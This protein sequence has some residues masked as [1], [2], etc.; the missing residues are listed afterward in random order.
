MPGDVSQTDKQRVLES[1]QAS[2]AHELR[3][4]ADRLRALPT[5]AWEADERERLKR[6]AQR[7]E[8]F[9]DGKLWEHKAECER[10]RWERIE[11]HGRIGRLVLEAARA[12]VRTGVMA[13]DLE[14][15]RRATETTDGF[16][17]PAAALAF[18][19]LLEGNALAGY[20]P[21]LSGLA[22]DRQIPAAADVVA[23]LWAKAGPADPEADAMTASAEAT[24][25][26]NADPGAELAA[27]PGNLSKEAKA[28]AA[29]IDHPEWS[30]Q[31]IANAAG[32]KRESLYRMKRFTSAKAKLR[33]GK[34]GMPRGRKDGGSGRVEAWDGDNDD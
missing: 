17:N 4:L 31:Q 24:A 6:A 30:D 14:L 23:G 20:F 7:L 21:S 19:E 27:A 13:L 18:N 12:G 9:A 11:L 34:G 15:L 3:A 28:L 32:C 2:F 5:E 33:E 1:L 29:L 8:P 22:K 10:R 16:D 25:G 26:D